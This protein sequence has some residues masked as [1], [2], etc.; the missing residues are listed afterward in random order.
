MTQ[1]PARGRGKP[2]P[3]AITAG[4]G[5]IS[6]LP[7]DGRAPSGASRMWRRAQKRPSGQ[8]TAAYL[9]AGYLLLKRILIIVKLIMLMSLPMKRYP[10]Q[11]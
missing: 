8:R 4:Y 7:F 2:R 1:R 3:F 11:Q 5:V 6:C 10:H 9:S